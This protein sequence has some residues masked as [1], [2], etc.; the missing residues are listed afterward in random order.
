MHFE[1]I[2]MAKTYIY[3]SICVKSKAG[4]KKVSHKVRDQYIRSKGCIN[5]PI[6]DGII[7]LGI[8][9][10][11]YY[12]MHMIVEML[13]IVTDTLCPQHILTQ[14]KESCRCTN[15]TS[16]ALSHHVPNIFNGV[17]RPC[18][19]GKNML[20]NMKIITLMEQHTTFLLQAWQQNQLNN[21][22]DVRR[23]ISVTSH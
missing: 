2:I 18:W 16:Q 6:I 23:V 10:D 4:N 20:C 13:I 22:L 17:L 14:Y 5:T 12:C 21:I 1:Y 11:M 8:N 15:R 19:P 7:P 9:T 3:F